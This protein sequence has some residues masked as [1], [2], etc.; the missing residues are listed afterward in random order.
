MTD[1][2]KH[3]GGRPT[4]YCQDILDKANLYLDDYNK[5]HDHIIPSVVGLA[6]V[7]DVTAKTLYNWSEQKENSKFLH[8]LERLNQRQHIKL[9]NG[10]LDGS[11]NAQITKLVLGK[12]G[13][14]DKVDTDVTSKGEKVSN[15][16][17]IQP[18]VNKTDG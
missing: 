2:P 4:K 10:G 1:K 5:K 7:L 3:P 18:V 11:L 9:I 15:N 14:H 12:H 17:I 13:Y 16:F 8:I 6:D